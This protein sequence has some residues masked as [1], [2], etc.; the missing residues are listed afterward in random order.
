MDNEFTVLDVFSG[1]GGLSE[2]FF[3]EGFEF[4]SHIDKDKNALMTLETRSIII[5]LARMERKT[6]ILDISE[7]IYQ[8]KIF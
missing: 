3:R 4:I 5:H 8:G 1:A 6:P 7:V 2:G